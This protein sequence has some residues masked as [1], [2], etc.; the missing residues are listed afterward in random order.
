MVPT[1]SGQISYLGSNAIVPLQCPVVDVPIG[2]EQHL[3]R[4]IVR[5]KILW[6]ASGVQPGCLGSDR[7]HPFGFST[8]R[9]Q[10][11][12]TGKFTCSCLSSGSASNRCYFTARNMFDKNMHVKPP[13]VIKLAVRPTVSGVYILEVTRLLRKDCHSCHKVGLQCTF[14]PNIAGAEKEVDQRA[15]LV[16]H[17][18]SGGGGNDG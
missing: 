11:V 17:Q 16:R 5:R 10:L 13:I 1:R 7:N 4:Q 6:L 18:G 2:E 9:S 8:S 15:T 12:L 3:A 14:N